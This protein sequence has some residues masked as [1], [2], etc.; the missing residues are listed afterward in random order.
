MDQF[1][2]EKAFQLIE[3]EKITLQLGSPTH[4]ILELNHKS[5]SKYDLGSL[6]AGLIAGMIAPEGLITRVDV[7]DSGAI[8]HAGF[9]LAYY[10]VVD[11]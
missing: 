1:E 10:M 4:Y 9:Q 8:L 5:R 11:R 7:A 6:R 2:V 3:Q